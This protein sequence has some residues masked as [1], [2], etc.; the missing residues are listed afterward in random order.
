M[1]PICA[2]GLVTVFAVLSLTAAHA[3][4]HISDGIV[5]IGVL[6]DESGPY[7]LAGSGSGWRALMAVEDFGAAARGMPSRSFSPTTRTIRRRLEASPG[8][9][10]RREGDVIVDVPT[11]S[12]TLAINQIAR[13]KG[14]ALLVSSGRYSALTANPARPTPFTGP[15]HWALANSTGKALVKSGANTGSSSPL[16]TPSATISRARWKAVVLQNGGK[17]RPYTSP[18]PDL[19]LFLVPAPGADLS[20][21]D[22]RLASTGPT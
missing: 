18:V 10:R 16:T 8:S 4:A 12:V 21:Q 14:K 22:H 9:V 11:S 2:A 6:N 1:T 3:H 17:C 7:A 5:K 19:G 13:D 15:T 20:G